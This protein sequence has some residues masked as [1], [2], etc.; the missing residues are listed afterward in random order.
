MAHTAITFEHYHRA[1]Q[2]S[3]RCARPAYVETYQMC[4]S[5]AVRI[6]IARSIRRFA[7]RVIRWTQRMEA[8]ALATGEVL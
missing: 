7:F 5:S 4:V 1:R 8:A 2:A 6:L 3:V